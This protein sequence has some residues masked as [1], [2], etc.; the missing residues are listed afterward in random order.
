[1]STALFIS[2]KLPKLLGSLL[3]EGTKVNKQGG[4][5]FG[6]PVAETPH[7]QCGGPGFDPWSG[8]WIPRTTTKTQH[9]QIKKYYLKN[10]INCQ[11]PLYQR[12]A[13]E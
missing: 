6:G 3:S 8:N 5:F 7:S 9:N 13:A 11:A 2:L 12:S 10:K 4:D 1:M